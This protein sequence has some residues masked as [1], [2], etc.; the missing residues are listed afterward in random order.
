VV[1]EAVEPLLLFQQLR[2]DLF[3]HHAAMFGLLDEVTVLRFR[4]AHLSGE[5]AHAQLKRNGPSRGDAECRKGANGEVEQH[6]PSV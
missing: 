1:G 6:R 5:F 4:F 2:L 3:T